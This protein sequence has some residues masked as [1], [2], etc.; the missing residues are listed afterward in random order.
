[1]NPEPGRTQIPQDLWLAWCEGMGEHHP[2]RKNGLLFVVPDDK[3]GA[4]SA[5]R[6][7]EAKKTGFE[8]LDPNKLPEQIEEAPVEGRPQLGSRPVRRD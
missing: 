1:M 7:V 3:A 8:P 2:A 5:L 6:D 4:K